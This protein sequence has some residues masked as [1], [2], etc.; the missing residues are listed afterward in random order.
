MPIW[1]MITVLRTVRSGPQGIEFV[2]I[3][4]HA[5][6]EVVRLRASSLLL[7]L[8]FLVLRFSAA[9]ALAAIMAL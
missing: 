7:L 3:I 4:C 2:S 5:G 8:V 9:L 6:S 1:G